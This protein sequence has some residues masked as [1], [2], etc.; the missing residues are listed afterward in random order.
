MTEI[1][2][3]QMMAKCGE[4]SQKKLLFAYVGSQLILNKIL[5]KMK[6]KDLRFQRVADMTRPLPNK[7]RLRLELF[8]FSLV[9]SMFVVREALTGRTL[10][11]F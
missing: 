1:T 11:Y 7:Q 10:V 8:T 9:N 4:I 2:C 3:E 6:I 5:K